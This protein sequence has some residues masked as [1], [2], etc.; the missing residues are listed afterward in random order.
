MKKIIL[1]TDGK[2]ILDFPYIIYVHFQCI[3]VVCDLQAS[4]M[5]WKQDKN[6]HI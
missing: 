6:V 3:K 4:D 1:C 5:Y 2:I